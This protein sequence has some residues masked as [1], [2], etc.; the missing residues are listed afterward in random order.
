MNRRLYLRKWLRALTI[1]ERKLLPPVARARNTFIKNTAVWYEKHGAVPNHLRVNH[2]NKLAD[3]LLAHY[4]VVMPYFGGMV[5]KQFKS[6]RRIQTKRATFFT[7]MAEWARTRAL[8]NASTIA[9]TD[10]GDVRKVI[11]NGLAEG[12]GTEQIARQIRDVT[13]LTPF[14][15]ATVART[16]THAAATFGA[17]E[18]ARQA[19]QEI[20]I[21]L[22]KEWLPT[23]DDRTRP[24]H[25]AMASY[26]P[27]PLDEKFEVD[28]E[29]MDRPGDPSASA[30]NLI[31]CRCACLTYEAPE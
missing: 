7:L 8:N 6:R 31:S 29:M 9:D 3:L 20:G 11:E 5:G 14:R 16:E 17:I 2:E 18:E 21:K 12:F 10:L 28:G 19:E 22:V 4:M 13:A 25:A 1:L 26:G 15:A 30:E 23:L 24:A 27:I